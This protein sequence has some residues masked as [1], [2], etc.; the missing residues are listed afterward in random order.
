M[1]EAVVSAPRRVLLAMWVWKKRL[2]RAAAG[3]AISRRTSSSQGPLGSRGWSQ[4]CRWLPRCGLRT[5]SA[6]SSSSPGP[7][8][9]WPPAPRPRRSQRWSQSRGSWREVRQG[10]NIQP[11]TKPWTN[12]AETYISSYIQY[13][14][15]ISQPASRDV[16]GGLIKLPNPTVK[17]PFQRK[18]VV[19]SQWV[20]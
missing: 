16:L 11:T 9:W 4:G 12:G 20:I 3:G 14:P 18:G 17:S 7:A 2:E 1:C 15:C 13:M 8:A 19:C 5:C 6:P 10:S